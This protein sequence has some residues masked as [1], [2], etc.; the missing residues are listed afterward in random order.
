[1][2]ELVDAGS[3]AVGRFIAD[4]RKALHIT[5]EELAQRLAD[6]GVPRKSSTIA[7]WETGQYPPPRELYEI[8]ARALEEPSAAVFYELAGVLAE[9]PGGKIVQMLRNASQKD[10]DRVE[11]MV[12]AYMKENE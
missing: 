11:R 5:Q 4:K 1:L 12:D 3:V 10:I 9:L 2:T 8:L 7:S 6:L